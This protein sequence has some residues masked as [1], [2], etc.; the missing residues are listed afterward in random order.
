MI[1]EGGEVL[2]VSAH[3]IRCHS[4]GYIGGFTKD[5]RLII[6]LWNKAYTKATPSKPYCSIHQKTSPL[7][8]KYPY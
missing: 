5:E 6:I 1:E 8:R 4:L 2:K 7:T 3:V